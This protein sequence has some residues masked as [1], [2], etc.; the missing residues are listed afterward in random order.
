MRLPVEF[1]AG[2]ALVNYFRQE[3][4]VKRKCLVRADVYVISFIS[5]YYIY[6]TRP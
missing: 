5:V 1:S 3:C 2:V 6:W 4:Y